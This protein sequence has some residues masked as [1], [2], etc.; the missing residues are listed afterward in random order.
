M[1]ATLMTPMIFNKNLGEE[2]HSSKILKRE[3]EKAF[4]TFFHFGWT[5][6]WFPLIMNGQHLDFDSHWCMEIA[7]EKFGNVKFGI[8]NGQQARIENDCRNNL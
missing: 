2:R 1:K 6:H 5:T 8:S 7:R 4:I 3:N